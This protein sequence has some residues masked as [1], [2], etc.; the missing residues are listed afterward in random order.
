MSCERGNGAAVL[1]RL[2]RTKSFST[3][4][5][6]GYRPAPVCVRDRMR[7][8]EEEEEEEE[9]EKKKMRRRRRD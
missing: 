6:V 1:F 8:K 9:K 2:M 3:E 5:A 4:L 7:K